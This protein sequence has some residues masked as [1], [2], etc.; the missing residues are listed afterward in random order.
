MEVY[1]PHQHLVDGGL[2]VV[3]VDTL[4]ATILYLVLLVVHM[5]KVAQVVVEKEPIHLNPSL[6]NQAKLILAVVLVDRGLAVLVL[7][8]SCILN[9]VKI[10]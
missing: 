4:I 8:S 6:H 1:Q 5:V 10:F 9:L 2:L 7:L 3:V